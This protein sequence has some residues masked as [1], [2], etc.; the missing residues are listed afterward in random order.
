MS[1]IDPGETTKGFARFLTED[2]LMD[3]F[4]AR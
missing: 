1:D 4:S 3:Y 2:F